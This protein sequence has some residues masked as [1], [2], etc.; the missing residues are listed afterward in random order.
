MDGN[1]VIKP[2]TENSNSFRLSST[3]GVTSSSV[4]NADPFA[5]V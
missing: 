4:K 2:D 3:T 5:S 1:N